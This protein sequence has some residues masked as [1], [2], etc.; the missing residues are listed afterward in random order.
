MTEE[1]VTMLNDHFIQSEVE[2][3]RQQ[4]LSAAADYRRARSAARAHSL[5]DRL[6]AAVGHLAIGR[7]QNQSERTARAA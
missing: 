3:L 7:S 1:M 2:Y 5:R 4:R 6:A